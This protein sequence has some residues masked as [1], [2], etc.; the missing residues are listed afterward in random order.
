MNKS[1]VAFIVTLLAGAVAVA[2]CA[3]VAYRTDIHYSLRAFGGL[4]AAAFFIVGFIAKRPQWSVLAVALSATVG[5]TLVPLGL[6]IAHIIVYGT[7]FAA[8]ATAI[9]FLASLTGAFVRAGLAAGRANT[10]TA[11]LGVAVLTAIVYLW[12]PMFMRW[13]FPPQVL[14]KPVGEFA[15][16]R[17]DGTP[18]TLS[19]FK[20]KVIVLSFWASWCTPCG[21]ELRQLQ[22]FARTMSGDLAVRFIAVNADG[23]PT[24]SDAVAAG[25][26]F[27]L[28][29]HITLKTL[30]AQNTQV[31][32]FGVQ[33]FPALVV[34]DGSGRIRWRI[35]GYDTS[36]NWTGLLSHA[37]AMA[38]RPLSGHYS[39]KSR[40]KNGA[41]L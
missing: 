24:L 31:D 30:Y 12:P 25:R 21:Q 6:A 18:V 28:A 27:L 1:T 8:L 9:P 19:E 39:A 11:V 3:F 23:A 16:T 40:V 26:A 38:K 14:A 2:A 7:Y 37:I 29:H 33:A 41:S 10:V 4:I 32:R 13:A 17:A 15:F 36:I 35:H 5:G 22:V 34:V 20:G